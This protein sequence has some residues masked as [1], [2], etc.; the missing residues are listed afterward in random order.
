V[1][2][3]KRSASVPARPDEPYTLTHLEQKAA[4]RQ[5]ARN[6]GTGPRPRIKV[7]KQTV[8][9]GKKSVQLSVDHKDAETGELLLMESLGTG[10]PFVASFLTEQ[11]AFLAESDGTIREAVLNRHL[12][13]VQEIGPV[14]TVEAMLACQ[15]V[16]VHVVTMGIAKSVYG[17]SGDRRE[18]YLSQ[19]NKLGRTFSTQIDALKR[20][21]ST[22]AQK[23]V[24]EHRHYHLAPGSQ[25]VFGDVTGAPQGG[26]ETETGDLPHER[27]LLSECPPVHGH[28][29]ANGVPMPGAS[30][31]RLEGVPISRRTRRA[32]ARTDA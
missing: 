8:K 26:G 30:G 13:L 21:R 28:V 32:G 27:M 14:D 4:E 24:V 31:E 9:D 2:R 17:S 22:G 23:V 29:K 20:Y 19:L 1:T 11:L 12:A 5:V 15:M 3:S 25:A 7:V 18:V 10:S 6:A 16:A